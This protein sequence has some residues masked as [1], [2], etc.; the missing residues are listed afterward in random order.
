[1]G[2]Y[3]PGSDSIIGFSDNAKYMLTK[4]YTGKTRDSSDSYTSDSPWR[5]IVYTESSRYLV[6]NI[7]ESK[8]MLTVSG[9]KCGFLSD[10][11]HLVVYE[12]KEMQN[13][14]NHHVYSISNKNHSIINFNSSKNDELEE[15][16]KS[17]QSEIDK[18]F[19]DRLIVDDKNYKMNLKKEILNNGKIYG[20][21]I[22]KNKIQ[23][24]RE[25]I[26]N[27]I[28]EYPGNSAYFDN[29]GK[30]FFITSKANTEIWDFENF[31]VHKHLL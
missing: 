16:I 13:Y 7:I 27:I 26:K 4:T 8:A 29:T 10:G 11:E 31:L 19:D 1:V 6:Y 30:Y 2:T 23:L 24:F 15:Y 25:D 5:G 21:N 28:A 12:N 18:F 17:N 3:I 22:T 9:N 14:E 20:L